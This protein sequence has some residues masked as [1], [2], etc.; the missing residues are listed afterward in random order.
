MLSI[1]HLLDLQVDEEGEHNDDIQQL[2]LRSIRNNIAES[3]NGH[4]NHNV[5]KHVMIAI[6]GDIL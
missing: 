5:I 6:D 3:N 2:T 1:A 4:C